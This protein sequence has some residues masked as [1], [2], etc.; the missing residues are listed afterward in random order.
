MLRVLPRYCFFFF[1]GVGVGVG[2]VRVGKWESGEGMYVVVPLILLL[3][4]T[5]TRKLLFKCE[6][7]LA[8]SIRIRIWG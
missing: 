7:F 3:S 5:L 1:V 8:Y 6:V 2:V 4:Y